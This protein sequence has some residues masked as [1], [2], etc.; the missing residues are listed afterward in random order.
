MSVKWFDDLK[1]DASSGNIPATFQSIM[2]NYSISVNSGTLVNGLTVNGLDLS[3]NGSSGG[4]NYSAKYNL[5][6]DGSSYI[7]VGFSISSYKFKGG[8]NVLVSQPSPPSY[9]VFS[10]DFSSD[11]TYLGVA[12]GLDPFLSIYKASGGG[13]TKLPTIS[14]MPTDTAR[15]VT[16]S[17]NTSYLAVAHSGDPFITIY[18]RSGDTFSKLGGPNINPTNYCNDVSFSPDDV[19]LAV[20]QYLDPCLII[21]KR[22]GDTFTKLTN[23]DSLPTGGCTGVAFSSDGNYLAVTHNDSPYIS[24]Y[25]RA[26]DVF[27]K[28][29]N[30]ATLPTGSATGVCFSP[31]TNYLSVVHDTS[32][33]VTVY[34]RSGDT[35]TKVSNPDV[36]PAGTAHKC[37]FSPSGDYLAVSHR[38]S[39]YVTIY[40]KTGDT[41][42]KM[43]DPDILPSGNGFGVKYSPDGNFFAL[44]YATSPYLKIYKPVEENVIFSVSNSTNESEL[45]NFKQYAKLF[46]TVNDSTL[47]LS[48][49]DNTNTR[50]N[51]STY[52]F[53]TGGYS[54]SN[55]INMYLEL[56]I[57]GTTATLYANNTPISTLTN[58]Y[59]STIPTTNQT[60][61]F[62]RDAPAGT[63]ENL[64]TLIK[65]VY[66][67]N[68]TGAPSTRIGP[69]DVTVH[70]PIADISIT[71]WVPDTGATAYNRINENPV[72]ESSYIK[73]NLDGSIV[74][75]DLGSIGYDVSQVICASVNIFGKSSY[76]TADVMR[77]ND[78]K[79]VTVSTTSA[80]RQSV[81]P[82]SSDL[83]GNVKV[84][85][86]Y[87]KE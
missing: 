60:V 39:P 57:N 58:S 82:S 54:D 67:L 6:A 48:L 29:A 74:E 46:A 53:A 44:G 38:N 73:T 20:A 2:D 50:Y 71:G 27:T 86:Q 80:I 32:P 25:K 22:S 77:I 35:F 1:M 87:I 68:G 5:P 41:L 40:K 63:N 15:G 36:L 64:S 33:Y 13:F 65:N 4:I 56:E 18:K 3:Y 30:P 69:I 78:D 14:Q 55:F 7:A 16:F 47:K 34:K 31:D 70:R 42:T 21:Y 72:V 84:K 45:V 17:S 26:G 12:Q 83:S 24:I 43:T 9:L 85:L 66:Y 79:E 51:G 8:V 52:S 62:Y 49:I 11:S 76:S 28:V 81:V 37:A 75:L 23:P 59:I 10:V 19:H 61:C